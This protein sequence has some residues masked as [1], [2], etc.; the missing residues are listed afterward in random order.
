M[1]D[2]GRVVLDAAADEVR[3]SATTVSG[4]MTAVEE[5]VVGRTIWDRAGRLAGVGRDRRELDDGDWLGPR[6]APQPRISFTPTGDGPLRR[7]SRR[8]H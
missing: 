6:A 8:R 1:I 4:P 5:F 3:G 7:P 2:H